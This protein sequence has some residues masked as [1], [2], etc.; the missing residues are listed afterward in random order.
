M[1][2]FLLSILLICI[3]S[4]SLEAQAYSPL[5]VEGNFWS[6]N[7][8]QDTVE[9]KLSELIDLFEGNAK[10]NHLIRKANN[11]HDLARFLQVS[12][13]FL[14]IYPLFNAAI[15]REP[16]Y[17]MSLIG[18]GFW[19]ISVPLEISSQHKA[20]KAVTLYNQ[21][22]REGLKAHLLIQNKGIGL[23]LRF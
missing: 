22:M 6:Q 5:E 14:A 8:L 17:N 20:Q 13:T 23:S 21:R 3:A 19:G 12:G 10:A 2:S 15:G 7:Y 16:N 9:Y 18:L 1:K 11:Q 4:G